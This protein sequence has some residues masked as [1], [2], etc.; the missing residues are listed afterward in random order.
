MGP[1]ITTPSQR[2][3]CYCCPG[4]QEEYLGGGIYVHCLFVC[5]FVYRGTDDAVTSFRAPGLSRG[6]DIWRHNDTGSVIAS[7]GRFCNDPR[8]TFVFGTRV[9]YCHHVTYDNIWT[10]WCA[11][12]L[13]STCRGGGAIQE[14]TVTVTAT[15]TYP[16]DLKQMIAVIWHVAA[17]PHTG[18]IRQ[19]AP[20]CTPYLIRHGSLCP[21]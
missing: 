13:R 10:M 11:V 6:A 16:V 19:V 21:H 3:Q 18:C 9:P 17:S 2:S 15:V 4:E 20:M 8:Y 5:V 12:G 14:T 7:A 1:K